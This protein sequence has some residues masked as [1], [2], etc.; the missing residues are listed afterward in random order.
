M[1]KPKLWESLEILVSSLKKS[2]KWFLREVH[3]PCGA[4]HRGDRDITTGRNTE[5]GCRKR[6]LVH[7]GQ[8]LNLRH[9]TP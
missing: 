1:V 3:L 9:A 4:T 5:A 2:E 6:D 8:Q 7:P